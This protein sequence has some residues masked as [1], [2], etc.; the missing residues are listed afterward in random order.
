MTRCSACARQATRTLLLG[1]LPV[2][3]CWWHAPHTEFGTVFQGHAAR[4]DHV[5][6]PSRFCR[7]PGC[8]LTATLTSEVCW[9]HG[10]AL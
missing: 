9:S 8:G 1:P 4:P 6:R 3:V 2:P 10:G 5:G 7:R